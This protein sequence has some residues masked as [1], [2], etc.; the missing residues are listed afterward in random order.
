MQ[1]D[2][3]PG[4]RGRDRSGGGGSRMNP[5]FIGIVVGL[6][7]GVGLAVA[8]AWWLDRGANQKVKPIDPLAPKIGKADL[9]N[10]EPPK[11][12]VGQL[13]PQ[14]A[15]KETSGK[16][17]EKA[18]EKAG[19]KPRFEFYQTLPGEKG[20][21]G[22]SGAK[23]A[24]TKRDKPADAATGGGKEIYMLQAGAFQNESDADALKAKIA[25]AGMEATVKPVNLPDKGTLY[26]V[27]VGPFRSVD[28]VNRV[29]TALAQNGVIAVVV[30]PE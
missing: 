24:D 18:G 20:A 7:V 9:P 10:L 12:G 1:A 4:S 8:A 13:A 5:L 21:K 26:R 11:P 22:E 17:G 14:V 27:R 3:R 25:F 29:K 23:P 6:L 16:A 2:E 30:R 19:D 28:E 15:V